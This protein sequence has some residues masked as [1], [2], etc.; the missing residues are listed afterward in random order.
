MFK[1]TKSATMTESNSF[2]TNAIDRIAEG[3]IFEGNITSPQGIRIDGTVKGSIKCDGKI[4]VGKNGVVEG[5]I[6]CIQADIEGTLKSS[7]K[8]EDLLE[9]KSTSSLYGE[10]I[11]GRLSIE[12][13]ATFTGN[14][15]MGGVVKGFNKEEKAELVEE[16][17]A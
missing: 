10:I 7:I 17:T 14:S 1:N 15:N 4:V 3:S 11:T 8:V 2:D 9:L 5:E 12:A 16:K 13:G 6:E